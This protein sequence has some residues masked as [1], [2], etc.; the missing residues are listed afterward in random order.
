[1]SYYPSV[2]K[3]SPVG[4][5]KL[6]E[7]S[8]SIAYDSSGCGNNG[9]YLGVLDR[10]DIPL[11]PNGMHA[12]KISSTNTLSFSITKD[13]SGQSGVGGF[14][15]AKT[16]DNDFSLEVWFHPKNLTSLTPIFA[17]SNGI[18]IYWDNGNIVFKLES[19][20]I[21]YGVPYENQSFHVVATYEINCL[22][23]Y[24]NAE[25]VATKYINPITFTNESL[26]LDIGPSESSEYFLVDAP[27]VY[28]Y[29]LNINQIKLH[30]QHTLTNTSVQIVKSNFGQLFKSTLQHQDQP[31]Q[32]TWPAYIPFS[33]F[34]SDNIG[35]RKESNSLYLKGSPGS[36]FIT[37]ISP[38]PHKTYVSSKIEWFGSKGI[39]VYSSLD[40]DGENTIWEECE[41]ASFI[42]GIRLGQ[43][44]PNNK[45][46]YFKVVFNTYD[47]NT[48][49]PEL[50]YMGSY[51]YENK[52]MFSH[53]G[54][55]LI[56][57]SEPSS[58]IEW[59]VN[60]S[61]REYQILSRHYD[62]GVRS[63]GAGFYV[64]TVDNIRSLEMVFVPEAIGSGYLFYNKT[65][66]VEYSL[67]WASNGTILKSN[68][69]GL[70]I[71]GQDASSAT[72]ISEYINVGEPN[73]ILIKTSLAISGQI[74]INTKSDN[75]VRSG[76]LPNNL[77]NIIAIYEGID[78]DHSINYSFYTGD[79]ILSA[80]DSAVTLTDMGPKA[81]DFDWVVLDNA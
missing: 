36:Y 46:M 76:T 31:D 6:D 65:N 61:N 5:W 50:Y 44:F 20:R 72:N 77:Y 15:I 81:Y 67:S 14:G 71:N 19:E 47:I 75:N 69:S 57:V 53:N 11:V 59:D 26:T 8:G 21:D 52:K 63:M 35:F 22:K 34:E 42:P 55:S 17:D 23:L 1:M 32:F 54:R 33:L 12:N 13:F 43:E 78:I 49:V 2:L 27:A 39:S 51:L 40:Y 74:W 25:L 80:N 7:E 10:V 45:Q 37:S 58:A 41:N 70:Y 38:K 48:H 29:A 4:F 30:Y 64:D 3:D 68:V 62:N 60:F 56:S 18:G 9:S 73:Y 24:V 16:E 28:R 66:S 79:H